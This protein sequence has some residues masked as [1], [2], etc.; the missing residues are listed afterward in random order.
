[1]T[2]WRPAERIADLPQFGVKK[3]GRFWMLVDMDTGAQ[4]GPGDHTGKGACIAYAHERIRDQATVIPE[5]PG[6]M[7]PGNPV[8]AIDAHTRDGVVLRWVFPEPVQQARF[9]WGVGEL[10]GRL[11]LSRFPYLELPEPEG[12]HQKGEA[13]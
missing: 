11:G 10:F 12:S 7:T 4:L 5:F 6:E 9:M 2:D 8:T 3:N 1:M 13:P